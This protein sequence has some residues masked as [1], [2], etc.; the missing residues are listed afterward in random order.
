MSRPSSQT[1]EQRGTARTGERLALS[2]GAQWAAWFSM[3]Q[4]PNLEAAERHGECGGLGRLKGNANSEP[5]SSARVRHVDHHLKTVKWNTP[6]ESL[7]GSRTAGYTEIDGRRARHGD[8][9]PGP[10]AWALEHKDRNCKFIL[11]YTEN[12]RPAGTV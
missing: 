9:G 7:G 11:S 1:R 6:Q 3:R 12:S 2:T 10:I 5:L 8:P 4:G